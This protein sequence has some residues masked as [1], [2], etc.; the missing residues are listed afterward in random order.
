M[1]TSPDVYDEFANRYESVMQPLERWFLT[2]LRQ[3]AFEYLPS[4]GTILELGAGTGLNFRFYSGSVSVAATEPSTEMIKIAA[5]KQRPPGMRLV[6]GRAEQLPFRDHSF[7]AA[8]AT[9]VM[10]SVE[11]VANAFVELRRIVRPGGT[12]ILLDHVRPDGILGPVFDLL[13][14]VTSRL[15][16]DHF[17]RRTAEAARAAG[18]EVTTR[19]KHLRGII[20]LLVCRV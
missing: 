9:L 20:N 15:F 3:R 17:N 13:N 2:R 1:K 19:E 10:C 8:V 16:A 7:D 11:S 14:S 5:Q 6:Q 18:L 12:V 4:S